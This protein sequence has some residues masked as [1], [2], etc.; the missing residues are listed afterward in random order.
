[1][2]RAIQDVPSVDQQSPSSLTKDPSHEPGLSPLAVVFLMRK[3]KTDPHCK[4]PKEIRKVAGG[5]TRE[6]Q[7]RGHENEDEENLTSRLAEYLAT[8]DC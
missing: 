7:R 8:V 4:K 3:T 6:S 5:G 1:M 2:S